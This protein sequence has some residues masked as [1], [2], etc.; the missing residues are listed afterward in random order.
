MELVP[1][2]WGEAS[3]GEL[4]VEPQGLYTCFSACCHLPDSGLWCVWAVGD[5]GELRVGVAEPQGDMATISRRF[6]GQQTQTLGGLRR[7][8]LRP[9]GEQSQKCQ[10]WQPLGRPEQW[11]STPWLR[12]QLSQLQGVLIHRTEEGCRLAIPW[13]CG[14]PFPLTQLFCLASL[15]QLEGGPYLIFNF[16][17]RETP[18][19]GQER[20]L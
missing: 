15:C 19:F 8:L 1:I 20:C 13:D 3:V 10:D 4:R 17:R 11:F 9:A 18:I 16:D 5:R 2:C 14:K 6:S 7:A 12:A